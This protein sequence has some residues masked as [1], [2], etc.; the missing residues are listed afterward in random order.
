MIDSGIQSRQ[1]LSVP[2]SKRR[3]IVVGDLLGVFAA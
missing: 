1:L 2:L 3:E